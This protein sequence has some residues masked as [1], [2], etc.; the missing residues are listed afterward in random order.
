MEVVYWEGQ[1]LFLLDQTKLPHQTTYVACSRYQEVAEAIYSLKVRGAPAIGVAAAYG[2]ALAAFN[3]RADP[4]LPLEQ[5]LDQAERELL[6]TRPTAVNLRWAL[7]RM[8]DAYLNI[9]EKSLDNIRSV[10]LEAALAIHNRERKLEE[11]MADFGASLVPPEANI[12]TYCNTGALATAGWGTALGVIRAAHNPGKSIKTFVPETRPVLQGAR[13]TAWELHDAGI[14]FTLIPDTMLGYVFLHEGIDLVLVGADRIV[15]NGDF[16]N[17]IGTYGLAVL[18]NYHNCP[19]YVVAP[20][21]TIDL[22]LEE[23]K[24][25]PIEMRDPRE[26]RELGGQLVSVKNCA[27][28][29]P[30]FDVT[31]HH[32]VTAVIT[33][34]GVLKP[35]L[36]KSIRR[37][38]DE[39]GVQR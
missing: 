10:L 20:S 30:A 24:E 2:Y 35:P 28:L 17:K 31:P 6:A 33:E 29:N 22:D 38:F 36:E 32:L 15:A 7:E 3:Y 5:F 16:A 4:G 23:G 13:L 27:V 39:E 37:S 11:K 9:Q 12:L 34:K 1:R 21:S 26:V 8:R 14:P 19:F 18:A 25:I